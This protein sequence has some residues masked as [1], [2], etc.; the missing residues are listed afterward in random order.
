VAAADQQKQ[1]SQMLPSDGTGPRDCAETPGAAAF[2]HKRHD[3]EI[4][5]TFPASSNLQ[6]LP[7]CVA[8][9]QNP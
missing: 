9:L 1:R 8:P 7:F 6:P 5:A 3:V 4:M 2:C